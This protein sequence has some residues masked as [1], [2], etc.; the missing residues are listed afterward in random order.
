MSSPLFTAINGFVFTV[1]IILLLISF[2]KK[3]VFTS[4]AAWEK[5]SKKRNYL[6][7]GFMLTLFSLL[8]YLISESA[9]LLSASS[10]ASEFEMIHET[11]E[12]V[13]MIIAA[14]ALILVV[15]VSRIM[16]EGEDAT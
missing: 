14:F 4:E 13:H 8:I 16:L 5:L 11:G 12:I 2:S 7:T 15:V 6:K 3:K 1:G 10:E 9:E